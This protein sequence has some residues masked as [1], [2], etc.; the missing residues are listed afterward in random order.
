MKKDYFLTF[1]LSLYE[2]L[3]QRCRDD[4]D[5]GYD[6]NDV[7]GRDGSGGGVR[8]GGSGVCVRDGVVDGVVDGVGVSDEY[9]FSNQIVI[10]RSFP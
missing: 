5:D 7:E 10:D 6:D 1:H 9:L 8:S 2:R 4:N 3:E